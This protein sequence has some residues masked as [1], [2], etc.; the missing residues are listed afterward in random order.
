MCRR[1]RPALYRPRRRARRSGRRARNRIDESSRGHFIYRRQA[2]DLYLWEHAPPNRISCAALAAL[3]LRASRRSSLRASEARRPQRVLLDVAR[4]RAAIHQ[5]RHSPHRTCRR[6]HRR[7]VARGGNPTSHTDPTFEKQW[8]ALN[9][10]GASVPRPDRL[11]PPWFGHRARLLGARRDARLAREPLPST[12]NRASAASMPS[13]FR[14]RPSNPSG[15]SSSSLAS[16]T[17]PAPSTTPAHNLTDMR[18]PY[19]RIAL[20]VLKDIEPRLQSFQSAITPSFTP[21][22]RTRFQQASAAAQAALISYRTGSRPKAPRTL[23]EDSSGP[24]GLPLLPPQRSPHVLDP[25]ADAHRRPPGVGALRSLRKPRP[26][27]QHRQA[28]PTHLPQPSGPD[29]KRRQSR[30]GNPRLPHQP[31]HPLRST[32]HPALL[33]PPHPPLLE[34]LSF[35]G[36]TD[37][38]TG[39]TRLTENSVSYKRPPSTG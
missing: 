5:R 18:G 24:R 25:G 13:S 26:G 32:L 6:L 4:D 3:F 31:R 39:P 35:L 9:T 7:L 27:R 36:V 38:L 19:M 29:R 34:A 16:K 22:N 14:R 1:C 8:R 33:R 23:R 15:R 28:L 2:P 10:T 12:S 37:D 21:G 30:T 11:P 20:A 17:F